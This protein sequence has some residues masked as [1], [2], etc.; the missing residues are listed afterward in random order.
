MSR[1]V[2]ALVGVVL[3]VV[4]FVAAPAAQER[5]LPGWV[6]ITGVA[7]NGEGAPLTGKYIWYLPW[8][9]ARGSVTLTYKAARPINPGGYADDTGRFKIS[10]PPSFAAPGTRFTV[11]IDVIQFDGGDVATRAGAPLILTI[12]DPPASMDLGRVVIIRRKR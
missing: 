1:H 5:P 4:A 12:A 7:V 3:A 2:L 9:A 10:V 8:N 6:E 11:G